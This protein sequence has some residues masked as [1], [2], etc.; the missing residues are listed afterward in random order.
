MG[1]LLTV[2]GSPDPRSA[3]SRFLACLSEFTPRPLQ[4]S[5]D[6]SELPAFRPADDAAPWSPAVLEWRKQWREAHGVIFSTPS[7]LHN[8]PGIVKNGLDW[9][10]TSGEAE[11]K[12]I[13]AFTFTPGAPRGKRARQS[14][15]WSLQALNARVLL[16]G[17]FYRPDFNFGATPPAVESARE[18]LREA[19]RLFE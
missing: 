19:L 3:N 4:V 15:L 8:L 7:Y 14:L 17:G 1:F 6:L 10:A 12:P 16:E 13:L 2:S 11:D 18:V 5:L 9:L